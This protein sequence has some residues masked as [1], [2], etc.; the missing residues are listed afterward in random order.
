MSGDPA[1]QVSLEGV[2]PDRGETPRDLLLQPADELFAAGASVVLVPED[3]ARSPA[4]LAALIERERISVWYSVPSILQLLVASGVLARTDASS[5][6]Y[7]LFAGE[8]FPV[9]HLRRLRE[10]LPH[11]AF[12]N[13]YG[14]TETNVCTSYRV[15]ELDPG[16]TR[17]VPIG[18]PLPGA[19]GRLVDP[20]G[21]PVPPGEV[22]ELVIEGDC[23]TPGYWKVEG[24]RNA[25][26]H[27]RGAHATGDLVGIEDGEFVYHGRIDHMLK[28]RGYRVEPGEIEAVLEAHPAIDRVA[29]DSDGEIRLV[30]CYELIPF[31]Y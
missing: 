8:V 2:R 21:R 15:G 12:Y 31:V 18:R 14:P 11:P 22:G 20:E 17:P 13:L 1:R 26:N 9:K 5:L 6:R 29:V 10:L 4:A 3:E 28:V 30:A 19:S 16:R 24:D 7:V 27:R 23:V 25:E